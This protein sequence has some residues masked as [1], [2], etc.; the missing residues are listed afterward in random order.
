[1]F[2]L[3]IFLSSELEWKKAQSNGRFISENPNSTKFHRG[4]HLNAMASPWV[5]WE[6]NSS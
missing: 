3:W 1:M 5:K 6:R 4:F 2:S